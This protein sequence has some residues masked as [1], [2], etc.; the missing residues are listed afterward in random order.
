MEY[1]IENVLQP[2]LA[3]SY[4][5]SEDG[6]TYTFHLR[7]G[8][9]WVDS[10]GRKVADVK[11]DDFVAGM[12]HLIDAGGG[13]EALLDGLILNASAYLNGEITDFSQV[14]VKALDDYTVEIGRAHV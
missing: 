13:L 5:V 1:D 11:A 2:A 14:G 7:E 12:E 4:D 3:E 10:Q 6:L 8:V 9:S